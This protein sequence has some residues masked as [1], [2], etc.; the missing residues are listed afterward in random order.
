MKRLHVKSLS[1]NFIVHTRGGVEVKGY[2]DIS[3]EV[4]NG[5]FLSLFGPSGAGKSSILKTLF[6]TYNA[7][8]GQILFTCNNGKTVDLASVDASTILELRKN[9]IGYVS[10][11]LQILP[12]VSAVGIVSEQLVLRGESQESS[13]QKA[14]EMLSFLSIKEELFD[15]SPLTFSGGEQQRVNIAKGIIAPK[16]LLLL[17]EPTAS[18]DK[19]NT[20]KVV[21]KLLELKEQG[22]AMVGIFHDVEAMKRIS[23][24]IFELKRVS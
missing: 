2:E 1:K 24:K 10:Q 14:K 16:S 13:R 3:F 19:E 7:T 18:L 5:E 6:R 17:D 21:E 23:S 15:L 9:E 8:S 20:M 11:F 12:R 22:V 4:K